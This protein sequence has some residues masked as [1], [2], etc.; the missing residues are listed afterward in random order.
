MLGH[1]RSMATYRGVEQRRLNH[2]RF[3]HLVDV[4]LV[5][6]GAEVKLIY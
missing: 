1:G 6:W 4:V 5:P 2:F 3:G